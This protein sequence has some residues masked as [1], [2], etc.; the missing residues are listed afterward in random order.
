MKPFKIV[1]IRLFLF[2]YLTSSYLSATHIHKRAVVSHTDCK[3]CLVVKNLNSGDV[4]IIQPETL[5]CGECYDSIVLEE[6]LTTYKQLKGFN[7]N[8]PPKLS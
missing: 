4:P 6:H 3:V 8:A 1:M 5:G 2:F 7:A